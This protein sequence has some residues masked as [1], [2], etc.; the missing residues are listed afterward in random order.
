[1]VNNQSGSIT[2][3]GVTIGAGDI[4]TVAGTLGTCTETG[5]GGPAS[6]ATL[7]FPIGITLDAGGNMWLADANSSTSGNT[8]RFVNAYTGLITTYAGNGTQGYTGDGGRATAAQLSDPAATVFDA[9]GNLYIADAGNNVIRKVYTGAGFA[10]TAT[11]SA[12]A[13]INVLVQINQSTNITGLSIP[14][15]QGG[16]TEYTIGTV[17]G[18][19]VD[20]T[21]N[22]TT[23]AGTVCTVPLTFNPAYPGVRSQALTFTNASAPTTSTVGLSGLGLGALTTITP[24]TINLFAGG[25]SGAIPGAA[26]GSA[27]D[28]AYSAAVDAAGNVYLADGPGSHVYKIS[29][30]N[31]S[32]FAGTTAGYSGDNGPATAAQLNGPVSVAVGPDGSVYIAETVSNAI[33]KVDVRGIITTVAGGQTAGFSGDGGLATGAQFNVL[34]Y[35]SVDAAGNLY[36]AD[37]NNHRIREVVAA[38]GVITTIAGTGA[39]GATG[40]GGP[41]V[42]ATLDLPVAVVLDGHGNL[43]FSDDASCTIREINLSTGTINRVAGIAGTCADSGNGGLA[44]SAGL[45]Y[46]FGLAVDAAGNLYIVGVVGR[47]IRKVDAA[48]GLIS[49]TAAYGTTGST[50]N[51]SIATVGEL[52]YPLGLMVDPTGVL[53]ISDLSDRQVRTIS[54][55]ASFLNFGI[56]P[57]GQTTA[58]QTVKLSNIG[59]TPLSISVVSIPTNFAQTAS[60]GTDCA[61]GTVAPGSSCLLALVFAP[62]FGAGPV[63]SGTVN[64]TDNVLL[65]ASP[66]T[67][68][69]SGTDTVPT[70]PAFSAIAL[71]FGNQTVGS[72]SATK[73]LTITNTGTNALNVTNV[74]AS[75]DFS[76]TNNCTT[77]V[78]SGNCTITVTFTPTASGLRSG[79]ISVID[80]ASNSPQLIRLSGIGISGSAAIVSLSN[81]ELNFGAQTINTTSAARTVTLTNGGG[82]ALTVS[83][84]SA[85]GNFAQTNNCGSVAASGACTINVTFTP[86]ATGALRG[87][88]VI[89]DSA[90]G[91]QVIRLLGTG[92]SPTTPAIGLSNVSLNFGN[93][94]T[95]TTSSAQTITVTNTGNATLTITGVVPTGDFA[96]SGCVTSLAA[97]ATCT[98]SVTFTP[99]VTGARH[100]TVAVTDNAAGSPQVIQLFGNG[101]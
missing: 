87:S 75:G 57:L 100:G 89:V 91:P 53:Y 83:N 10:P 80:N 47:V 24:G 16:V 93:Q 7:G 97:G 55:T 37:R 52:G 14:A 48:T 67:I 12:S 65:P 98:L 29:G 39:A 101:T 59:N 27:P 99:T 5:D 32:V 45:N 2:L 4:H 44:T 17:T 92:T 15:S 94:T 18:C 1:V 64:V 13:S 78:A 40:D 28:G 21:G 22:T 69:L 85:T 66:Q 72:S 77:V 49:T 73:T 51:G 41:A 62:A 42:D 26:V 8:V 34:A 35:A 58:S 76:Q 74:A 3:F 33:R 82:A 31:I 79:A 11:G 9:L 95:G 61:T 23:T 43:Y 88:V 46:P 63:N 86:T 38:S 71:N 56:E 25:G 36:I 96:A 60:G 50:G 81:V 19:T 90:T 84:I 70:D 30:G 54:P 6:Q 20:S 68:S